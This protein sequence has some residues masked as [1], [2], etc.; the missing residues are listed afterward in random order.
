MTEQSSR[1]LV[2]ALVASAC[3]LYALLGWSRFGTVHN[4]TFDLA[5]YTRLAWGLVHVDYWEPMVNAHMYGL[6]LSPVLIP[7]GLLGWLTDT[8]SV[9]I[10]AQAVALAL[11]AFPLA[12]LGRARWGPAGAVAAAVAWLLYP[13]LTHVAGYEVHPGAMAALPLAWMAYAIDG[14]RPRAFALSALGVLLCREDLALTILLA[15]GLFAAWHRAHARVALG[16]G[17]AAALYAAFF[18]LYLHPRYAPPAGSLQLHFGRF[19]S[20]LPEVAI[21]LLTHPGEL[22]AHLAAPRRLAYLPK[23]LGPLLLLPL[24]RPRWLIPA[25]PL[26]AINL[27]SEWPTT[28][29]LDVQ[30]LTPALPFLLAGALDG[31]ARLPAAARRLAPWGLIA[32]AAGGYALAGGGPLGAGFEP[33]AH[34]PDHDTGAAYAVVARVGP[35]ASVQAPY[36]LLPHLAERRTLHRTSTEE[37]GDDFYVLPIAHRRRFAG[38]EDLIRTVEEPP[39]RDW[40]ARDDHALVL[41]AGDYLLLARGQHPRQGLGA[42]AIVGRADPA[43]GVA[44]SACLAV[45]GASIE[46]DVLRLDLVAR[47]PC[48]SDLAIRIGVEPRPRRV[49]LLFG[50]WLSPVHLARGDRLVSAHR[51]SGEERAAIAARGLRVGLIR[52]SG[53]RPEHADPTSVA[54]SLQD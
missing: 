16:V 32:G 33:D 26:L 22:A 3:A 49:D 25:L 4:E 45:L 1:R 6:H 42:R 7:L 15:S 51:L 47:G 27:V 39:V 8:A 20:S 13:N 41:A 36:A 19:G 54:V 14:G 2:V 44:L 11:A 10:G 34:A 43:Q 5:F 52:Q 23:I 40:L 31:A 17:A 46:Q 12:R 38:D 35:T 28:T 24:L 21:H 18:F 29:D 53:A 30:Y 48:P 50:G 9:L 37:A